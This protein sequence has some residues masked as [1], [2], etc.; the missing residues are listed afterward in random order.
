[1]KRTALTALILLIV[2]CA[3]AQRPQNIAAPDVDVRQA[4]P[5]FFGSNQNAAV[6]FDLTVTN[7]AA[8]AVN[9]QRVDVTSP[10][11]SDFT[12]S[13]GKMIN[14]TL[15]PGETKT[16]SFTANAATDVSGLVVEEAVRLRTSVTFRAGD[17]QWREIVDQVA[18]R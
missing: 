16:F 18:S 6:T 13:G 8:T 1:M 5:I 15:A 10:F 2:A 3:T 11:M 14:E 12:V 9:V 17:K 4:G 7:N